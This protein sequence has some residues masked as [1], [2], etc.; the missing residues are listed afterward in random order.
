MEQI[1]IIEI[2]K[3]KNGY[4]IKNEDEEV[5]ASNIE[6]VFE[7]ITAGVRGVVPAIIGDVVTLEMKLKK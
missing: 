4:V 1:A 2:R 7:E 6:G 3:V 5:I